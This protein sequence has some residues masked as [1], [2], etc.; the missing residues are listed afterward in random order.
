M[1]G[2]LFQISCEN[3]FCVK[4]HQFYGWLAKCGASQDAT[5]DFTCEYDWHATFRVDTWSDHVF[6]ARHSSMPYG[7][8]KTRSTRIYWAFPRI[9]CLADISIVALRVVPTTT[10]LFWLTKVKASLEELSTVWKIN[11]GTPTQIKGWLYKTNHHHRVENALLQRRNVSSELV[12]VQRNCL[13]WG[14]TFTCSLNFLSKWNHLLYLG[15]YMNNFM[16]SSHKQRRRNCN[17]GL[18]TRLFVFY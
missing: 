15:A 11:K 8:A 10:Q 12:F 7:R 18:I 2:E 5:E 9:S 6:V 1:L 13:L 16:C 14:L 4:F 17:P 3:V